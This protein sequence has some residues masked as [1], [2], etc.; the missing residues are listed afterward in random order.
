MTTTRLVS[1]GW[2]KRCRVCE[3]QSHAKW[4]DL[5]QG[6]LNPVALIDWIE[7]L[8]DVGGQVQLKARIVGYVLGCT[9]ID[10]Q[11]LRAALAAER[12]G[13]AGRG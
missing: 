11:A 7:A 2:G 4:H 10:H 9:G 8:P 13:E 3:R 12:T 1:H 5:A 6:E